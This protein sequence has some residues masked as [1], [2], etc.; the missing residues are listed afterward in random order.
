MALRKA[1]GVVLILPGFY[2]ASLV[3]GG[4]VAIILL[5][6]RSKSCRV[7]LRFTI[8]I[9]WGFFT[10]MWLFS[11]PSLGLKLECFVLVPLVPL[12]VRYGGTLGGTA[13]LHLIY[14]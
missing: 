2:I 3:G 14:G 11:M 9:V 6:S 7:L 4:G 8:F 12:S 1:I 5:A 10:M 13:V